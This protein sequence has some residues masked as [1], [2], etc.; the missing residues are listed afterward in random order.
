MTRSQSCILFLAGLLLQ[1]SCMP[2][3]RSGCEAYQRR[4]SATI[5]Q[6]VAGAV[7]APSDAIGNGCQECPLSQATLRVWRAED[8][9]VT[10]DAAQSLAAA[11]PTF[12]VE[13]DQH[14]ELALDPADFLL[15]ASGGTS[16]PV[17]PCAAFSVVSGS[18]A[19]INVEIRNGPTSLLVFDANVSIP[20]PETFDFSAQ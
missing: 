18:V 3:Q 12:V 11:T 8:P 17:S 1:G 14:Y 9:I 2:C 10:G 4:A 13:A 15:C 5:R 6:G 16:I 20:R 19:T 7:A